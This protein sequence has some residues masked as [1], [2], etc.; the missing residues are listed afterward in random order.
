MASFDIVSKTD[1]AEIN[2]AISALLKEVANRYDFRGTIN[3]ARLQEKEKQIELIAAD[4][5]KMQAMKEMMASC[6]V[7]RKLDPRILDYGKEEK[8]SKGAIR[9]V[10]VIKQGIDQENAKKITKYIKSSKIK[11]QASIQGEEIR[12]NGKKRDDLQQVMAEI[13]ALNL[14]LPLQYVNFRD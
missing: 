13:K 8:A 5:Y 1:F 7:K 4:D 12:I 2:N 10:A 3:E 11:V 14:P 6:L 9:L